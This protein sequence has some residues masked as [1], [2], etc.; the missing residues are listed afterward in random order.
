MVWFDDKQKEILKSAKMTPDLDFVLKLFDIDIEEYLVLEKKYIN[1]FITIVPSMDDENKFILF[2]KLNEEKLIIFEDLI[3]QNFEDFDINELMAIYDQFKLNDKI[4]GLN[5]NNLFPF[6]TKQ[7]IDIYKKFDY[8]VPKLD[9]VQVVILELFLS[10]VLMGLHALSFL[11]KAENEIQ[12][13]KTLYAWKLNN[14]ICGW[15]KQFLK[16]CDDRYDY[17][18][19]ISCFIPVNFGKDQVGKEYF[20]PIEIYKNDKVS[21]YN[22]FYYEIL[23]NWTPRLIWVRKIIEQNKKS[24]K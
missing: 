9:A 8:E 22:S 21:S 20:Y 18:Y 17:E 12:I 3:L 23:T 4:T 16:N 10:N 2:N 15:V 7:G 1:N 14:Y 11:H 13:N 5:L 19:I 6:L 24:F